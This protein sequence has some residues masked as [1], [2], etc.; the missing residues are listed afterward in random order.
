VRY[1][2]D[3]E[4]R[5]GKALPGW[6]RCGC[7]ALAVATAI[8]AGPHALAQQT[9]GKHQS[10]ADQSK[11]AEKAKKAKEIDDAY[12]ATIQSIPNKP[13]GDPWGGMR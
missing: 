6:L 7:C 12:R 10:S 13:K 2:S 8:G 1:L 3:E 11:T 4:H 5:K 9:Q